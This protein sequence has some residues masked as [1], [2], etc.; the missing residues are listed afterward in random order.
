MSIAALHL[1]KPLPTTA[2]VRTWPAVT[3]RA[4]TREERD[5]LAAVPAPDPLVEFAGLESTWVR[6]FF[7]GWVRAAL[8]RNEARVWREEGALVAEMKAG[9]HRVSLLAAPYLAA[10]GDRKPAMVDVAGRGAASRPPARPAPLF[11]PRSHGWSGGTYA[12]H[13]VPRELD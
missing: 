3:T 6:T 2:A 12:S 8:E 5:W 7:C 4:L 10:K 11:S 9:V 1:T 13:S